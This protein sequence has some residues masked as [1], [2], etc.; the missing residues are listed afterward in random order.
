[1]GASGVA[2]GRTGAKAL[3]ALTSLTSGFKFSAAGAAPEAGNTAEGG[4][5]PRAHMLA[6]A[7]DKDST[8]HFTEDFSQPRKRVK[9]S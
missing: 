5:C 1:M 3:D 7:R 9:L 8:K 6:R 4:S 2:K